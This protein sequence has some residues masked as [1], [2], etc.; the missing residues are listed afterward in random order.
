MSA[1]KKVC[2]IGAGTM[3]SGIA[4]HLANAGVTVYLLD[5][6]VEGSNRSQIAQDA[7]DRQLKSQPPA[8]V[9]PDYAHQITA[10]NIEDDLAIVAEVDWVAEAV[11]ERLDIK[12][13]LYRRIDEL[14]R[15]GTPI[16][17]NTSTIPLRLLTRNMP[18]AFCE[19]F[20]ITHFFNPVRYMRLLEIVGGPSTRAEVISTLSDFCDQQLGKG[21]V[22]CKD[23]PGFLGN[24]IGVYAIQVAI[25][26]AIEMGLSIEEADA[27]MGR[28]IGW[29]KTGVFRLYDLIGLDLMLDVLKS[30]RDIVPPEDPFYAAAA[31]IP[32]I[33][34]L[35]DQGA[36][37]NKG[38]GGFFRQNKTEDG[39]SVPEAIDWATG[40]YRPAE[41]PSTTALDIVS[42]GGLRGL[43]ASDEVHG[44]YAWRVLSRTLAYAASL[45]PEI[46]D[47]IVPVD[48]AM[49]LGFSWARGPFEMIDELGVDWFADKLA[50]E[51][52]T[53]PPLIT[54]AVGPLYRNASGTLQH[55]RPGGE[56][57]DVHR[58]DRVLRLTDCKK[59][60]EPLLQNEAASL[61]DIGDDVACFE[62]HTK[63]NAIVPQTMHLLAQAIEL[64]QSGH[65]ALVIH[66][67]APHFSVGVNIQNIL[68][69]AQQGA[70]SNIET[71][72]QEFQQ[73]CRRLKYAPFP[74]VG[75][76]AGL[77]LGGGYEVLLHCDA[78]V[79]HTNCV[80]GLVE[81][82]VGLIPS[83]GGCKEM[84]FRWA[85]SEQPAEMVRNVFRFIGPGQTAS[86]PVLA[87]PF[88]FFLDRDR[89]IMNRDRIL[90]AAKEKATQLANGYVPPSPMSIVAA[91]P[92]GIDTVKETMSRWEKKG[93]LAPHDFR[94][95]EELARI[96]S[97]GDIAAGETV[98]EQ[99]LFDLEREAFMKLVRTPAT[100]ARIEYTLQNGK[101]LR[102]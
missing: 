60:R 23:T 16:S 15:P 29:P 94:V 102:N 96:F 62:F 85:N 97:G 24:R 82:S 3:G 11:V 77:S 45:I 44:R 101:P 59:T 86:S 93:I 68:D 84:L 43:V 2:V 80:L 47:E 34:K 48:E 5:L 1:I 99:Q 100:L 32:L 67:D 54:S 35:V 30:M 13:S 58:A 83:G 65:R 87:E 75:A 91:G 27:I 63:A 73:T 70:W 66:N 33:R 26:E 38:D 55:Q 98:S 19:D 74:V 69:D 18:D 22:P 6:P 31:E 89:H 8:F 76:P 95:A 78:L 81:S 20:C 50:S 36:T 39:Q 25:I 7:I 51:G 57:Q 52:R 46:S 12:E 72:L 9:H 79:S 61:W 71:M 56:Y 37:G 41:K 88:R 42:E 4:S 17:S 49:K 53:V 21:V 90:L 28:P 92:A 10:G 14:R 40:E 64:V